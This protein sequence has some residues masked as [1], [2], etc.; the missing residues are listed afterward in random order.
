MSSLKLWICRAVS[1]SDR[2]IICFCVVFPRPDFL[3]LVHYFKNAM[4]SETQ[5]GFKDC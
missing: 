4:N 5:F 2:N 1:P 3:F